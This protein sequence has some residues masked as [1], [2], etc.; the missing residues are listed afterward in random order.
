MMQASVITPAC[1]M[2][3]RLDYIGIQMFRAGQCTGNILATL[4]LCRHAINDQEFR[5]FV[6]FDETHR[7]QTA[8]RG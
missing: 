5:A 8:R 4:N 1:R 2:M 7:R 6:E 3:R